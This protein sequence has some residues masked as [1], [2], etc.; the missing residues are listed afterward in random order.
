MCAR[1]LQ[2]V[3]RSKEED[4]PAGWFSL[5]RTTGVC[6]RVTQIDLP[7]KT[8]NEVLTAYWRGNKGKVRQQKERIIVGNSKGEHDTAY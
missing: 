6:L 5:V 4:E 7:T 1:S 8:P 2:F 3:D